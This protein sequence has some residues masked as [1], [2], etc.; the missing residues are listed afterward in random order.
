MTPRTP[1]AMAALVALV[2]VTPAGATDVGVAGLKLVIVDALAATGK[3]KTVFVAKDA[4]IAKGD[5]GDPGLLSAELSVVYTDTSLTRAR[6]ALPSGPAW[7]ANKDTVARY[8]NKDAPAGGGVK[9]AVVK[10]GKVAKVVARSLGDD[11]IDLIGA[12]APGPQGITV[13]LTVDNGND[14]STTRLCTRFSTADGSTV[15]FKEIAGGS[16]RKIVAKNGAPVACPVELTL[17]NEDACEVLNQAEC[18]L[19]FPST[20]FLVPAATP[21][22]FQ[23]NLPQVGMPPVIGTPVPVA[24]LNALDGFSPTDQIMMHFPQGVDVELSDAARLLAAGCCGQPAGPPWIDTRTYTSRSLD[25]DSP[26][27]LLDAATGE[28]IL[29]FIEPDARAVGNPARQVLFLRPGRSL[30]PGHRY[31]V[32]MRD[33]KAP[34]GDDVVA[35]PAF[36]AIRDGILT[37]S[38][39]VERRRAY[40]ESDV[41]PVLAANGID[42]GSLVLAF[43]FVVQSEHQLTHQMLAMRDQAYTWLDA[44]EADPMAVNFTVTSVTEHDCDVPGQVVWRDVKG[45]FQSPLFLDG[46]M[47]NTGVQYLN[48]DADDVPVQNGTMD[49]AFD[50]SIPCSVLDPLVTSRPLL[51]GHGLFGRGSDMTLGIPPAAGQ[52]VPWTYIGGATDWRGLSNQDLLWV[53]QQIIGTGTSQLHHFPAFPDR[54]RQGMLNTLV[55]GRM[56]KRG[57]FNR[58]PAFQH[59]GD[60]VFPG[61]DEELYYYGISLGGIMG[62]WLAALTPDADRFGLDV[63]AIN[64]SCLLQ[65]STQF[66]SFEVLLSSIGLTDPMQTVIG[67][68]LLHELWVSAEPAGF[69]RHITTDPLPGTL[70]AK[71][72]L[73]TPAWLDKQV[74]NQCTEVAARTLGLSTLADGSLQQGLQEIPDAAGPLDSALVMYDTGSFDLFNPAHQP[75]IPPLANLIPSNVCDPHTR[76]PN[77]PAGVMQLVHFLQPGGQ[78]ANFCD[79]LCDAGSPVEVPTNPCTPP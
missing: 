58:D 29:H 62:T 12:G 35:E 17:A 46:P 56:M 75:Y 39:E 4:G 43:D 42:R 32:A 47:V 3:A 40:F 51:L 13:M 68:Q 22:G 21:T 65:R 76:R 60:G 72:I 69:A 53:I 52:I 54:L 15:S 14:A 45:T 55:L 27:V 33:L 78:V 16:G 74:S 48:V 23:M 66:S 73:M 79:G 61:A 6:F 28:R 57:L 30:V 64:F 34:N 36:T 26:S 50:V 71:R 18:L 11:P 7:L 31:V 10:P 38:L 19:P 24:P 8:V 5:A 1:L 77:I 67:E 44:V 59:D 70:T 20:R 9:V 2:R 41:F 37:T 49:A 63:P 25:P